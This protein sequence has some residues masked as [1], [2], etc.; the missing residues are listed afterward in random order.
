MSPLFSALPCDSAPLF[1][2]GSSSTSHSDVWA[3]Q[4]VKIE[5]AAVRSLGRGCELPHRLFHRYSYLQTG[6]DA[7]AQLY[8]VQYLQ[9]G[10]QYMS[11]DTAS[12]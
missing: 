8:E 2:A 10:F 4:P 6:T 11:S 9:V 1:S 7:K 3:T 5:G 12:N